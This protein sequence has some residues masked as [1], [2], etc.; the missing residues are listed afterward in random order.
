MC[1]SHC[2]LQSGGVT[3]R[4]SN[5]S[6]TSA[7]RYVWIFSLGLNYGPFFVPCLAID[8][9]FSAVPIFTKYRSNVVHLPDEAGRPFAMS[10]FSRRAY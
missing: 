5:V 6:D 3:V 1:R 7:D 4:L 8:M 9:W 10:V 2:T